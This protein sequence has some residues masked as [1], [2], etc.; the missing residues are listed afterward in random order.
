[1]K[2]R[3]IKIESWPSR[4]YR[5][6]AMIRLE[7]N[8]LEDRLGI[9]FADDY[10]D[11]DY[12]KHAVLVLSSGD[13][14]LLVRYRRAPQPGTEVNADAASDFARVRGQFL[15]DTGLAVSDVTWTP[16]GDGK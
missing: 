13:Q 16:D 11:L 14:L 3:Q 12:L 6:I 1:M 5:P 2:Y 8:E 15:T 7:P 4:N 9:R 10:D